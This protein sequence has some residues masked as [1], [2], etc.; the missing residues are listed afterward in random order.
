MTDIFEVQIGIPLY[1]NHKAEEN[2]FFI[3]NKESR[4][5]VFQTRNETEAQEIATQWNKIGVTW[6]KDGTLELP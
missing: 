5:I 3:I 4:E 2:Q 1:N 6:R